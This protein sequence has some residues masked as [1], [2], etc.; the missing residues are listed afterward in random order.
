MKQQNVLD[1][2]TRNGVNHIL[3]RGPDKS[4][5]ITPDLIQGPAEVVVM[6]LLTG[7]P[8]EQANMKSDL[9]Q[10]YTVSVC[11]AFWFRVLPA[12]R[13]RQEGP[14]I[15]VPIPQHT[16]GDKVELEGKNYSVEGFRGAGGRW[17][18]LRGAP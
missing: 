5:V 2:F 11:G 16:R 6:S 18:L 14:Q 1:E 17:L 10:F 3:V 9:E 13:G 7:E 8:V 4:V 12:F 15:Q